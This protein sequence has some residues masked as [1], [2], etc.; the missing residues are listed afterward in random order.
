MTGDLCES[1]SFS[2]SY[3]YSTEEIFRATWTRTT[4]GAWGVSCGMEQLA[5]R[6]IGWAEYRLQ[7]VDRHF[8]DSG[9]ILEAQLMHYC[10]IT[11]FQNMLKG[12]DKI[13]EDLELFTQTIV[14]YEGPVQYN[15]EDED[16]IESSTSTIVPKDI[17][18]RS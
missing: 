9:F 14:E 3:R 10:L 15:G 12:L 2:D 18:L 11:R 4:D 17:T 1:L 6:E 5:K 8:P 13:E 16:G 7:S